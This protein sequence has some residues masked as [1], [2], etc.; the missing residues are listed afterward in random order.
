MCE[1]GQKLSHKRQ[2]KVRVRMEGGY[3]SLEIS[4]DILP[5]PEIV[6]ELCG[7]LGMGDHWAVG[8][9]HM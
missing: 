1:E 6:G 5:D 9:L 4:V 3:Y 2:A 8:I 7:C